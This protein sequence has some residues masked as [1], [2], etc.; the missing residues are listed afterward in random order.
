M[1]DKVV[2]NAVENWMKK[3]SKTKCGQNNGWVKKKV[4]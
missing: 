1:I 2:E 4:V 3:R